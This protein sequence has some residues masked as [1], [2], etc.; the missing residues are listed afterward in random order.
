MCWA[1]PSWNGD[2]LKSTVELTKELSLRHRVLYIDYAYT[3]KDVL[4]AGQGSQ[5][6]V[7]N[8]TSSKKSIRQI[9]LSNGG[10]V[11]VLSLPP[12]MPYNWSA[13]VNVYKFLESLN[14]K[15]ISGRIKQALTELNFKP[16]IVI[17]AFNPFFGKATKQLFPNCPKIYY[18]YDNIDATVWASKHGS[19]LEKEFANS[20]DAVIFTSDSLKENK[21]FKVPA[22]V[23][24]NGVDLRI[25]NQASNVPGSA[26]EKSKPVIGYT[27]TIDNRL[28]FDML[29]TA[30]RTHEGYDF[31]FIG[32]V[33][34]TQAARLAKYGNV[35]FFGAVEP[36][37]LPEMM[38][39]FDAG[40][41]PFV[42]N[43]FT[44][45][46]YPMKVNEYLAL[47]IPVVST[48][49]AELNDL[50]DYM[51]VVND[52]AGF[53]SKIKEVTRTNNDAWKAARK[54]K[55]RANSWEQKAIEFENILMQY[56]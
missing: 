4:L 26:A 2:Y 19:W 35:K 14:T 49:F 10:T 54:Q 40:I 45:N 48:D 36:A 28:N 55:A 46:I 39:S 51:E 47:G 1:F 6:P 20:T 41:I 17:N 5:V 43:E 38:K 30:I 8:I 3:I 22:Y 24:K 37:Q 11:N 21:A 29:E 56:V 34:T 33:I 32:R 23:V 9:T 44:K 7:T 42:K 25:F 31:H 53:C 15:I 18:C 52:V 50:A 12:I 27:G 13:N 16:S